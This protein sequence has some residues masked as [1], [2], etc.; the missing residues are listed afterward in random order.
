[1]EYIAIVMGGTSQEKEVSFKSANTIH[2]YIDK[3][4]YISYKVL[5]LNINKFFVMSLEP[6][7]VSY[8][9]IGMFFTP[10]SAAPLPVNKGIMELVPRQK[11]QLKDNFPFSVCIS[12]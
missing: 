1:M 8:W 10:S 7:T 11:F 9:K 6:G 12:G 5:C 3:T 2:K 4:K